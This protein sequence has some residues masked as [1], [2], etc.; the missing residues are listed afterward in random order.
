MV[1]A[2]RVGLSTLGIL[3][4]VVC[5]RYEYDISKVQYSTWGR[6]IHTGRFPSGTRYKV[7]YLV[8]LFNLGIGIM[9]LFSGKFGNMVL[10]CTGRWYVLVL[11]SSSTRYE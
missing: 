10:Y 8:V 4:H 5:I 7:G 6:Y 2:N 9:K 1:S 3:C 11:Y